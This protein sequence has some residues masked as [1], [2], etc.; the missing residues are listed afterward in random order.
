MKNLEGQDITENVTSET[1]PW[2]SQLAIVPKP[3]NKISLCIDMFN[4]NKAV[5]AKKS[6]KKEIKLFP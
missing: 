4:A 3:G 6:W 2:L 1:T 5:L